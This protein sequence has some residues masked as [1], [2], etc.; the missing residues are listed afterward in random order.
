LVPASVTLELFKRTA[1]GRP[2]EGKARDW[3][4]VQKKRTGDGAPR[5]GNGGR[6]DPDL[7]RLAEV[8]TDQEV[9]AS[10]QS[11]SDADQTASDVDQTTSDTDRVLSARDQIASDRDQR[12]SDRDQAVS[13]L[14]LDANPATEA[15]ATHDANLAERK[16]GSIERMEAGQTRALAGE[17]RARQAERRDET[18]WHRDITAQA[19]DSAADRRDRE[20]AKIERKMG[21]RG[22]ALR[23]ALMHAA[24]VRAHAGK[25]RARAADDRAQA[26]AD[27]QRAADEREATLAE[28]RRAHLD[29]LTGAY[30]RGT[31]ETA[32]QNEIERARRKG[33]DL[34]L[35]FVDVDGLREVNNREGHSA[36]DS[37]LRDVVSSIRAKIRSYEPIVR[38][39]GDEFVCAV[40]GL[41]L[42]EAGERFGAIQADLAERG[43]TGVSV[44]LAQMRVGDTL[45][46]L[47]ERADAA[48]LDVR[49][50]RSN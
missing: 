16:A 18:A 1:G 10:D 34:V 28:L 46:E 30:R 32:L 6:P 21:S 50:S 49:R 22:T 44:G 8:T 33:D 5:Q 15:R 41:D 47:I 43:D 24:E 45:A 31:G 39:G 14:E 13:D 12:A 3:S 17:E 25:D 29:A 4:A 9:A 19:R 2:S 27:R 35:A 42:D 48:L 26:A 40:G 36:G 7:T 38:F 20:S 37:L 23:T 11:I